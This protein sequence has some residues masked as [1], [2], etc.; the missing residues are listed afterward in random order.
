MLDSDMLAVVLSVLVQS[1]LAVP[2]ELTV[3]Q[4]VR[5]LPVAAA[6]GGK[7]ARIDGVVTFAP[8][9]EGWFYVQDV[10]GGVRVEWPG[11]MRLGQHVIVLGTTTAGTFLPELRAA[12]VLAVGEPGAVRLPRPVEPLLTQD[13]SGY[14]DGRWVEVEVVI[15]RSWVHENWL[16]LDVARGRGQAVVYVPR[17]DAVAVQDAAKLSGAV[18]TVCGV[19][20]ASVNAGRQPSGPPQILVASFDALRNKLKDRVPAAPAVVQ[21][22]DLTHFQPDPIKARQLVV[23]VGVVTLNQ[24]GRQVH[25]GD[26]TGVVQVNLITDS[27]KV[28]PGDC[29]QVKGFPRAADPVRLEN[30]TLEVTGTGPVPAAQPGTPALAA[31]GRL[32]GQIV[33]FRGAVH[34]AGRQGAW[35]TLTV[36]AD[37]Q[38]FTA[39]LLEA[40]G[41]ADPPPAPPGS[42]VEVVGAVTRQPM[43]GIRKTAFVVAVRPGGLTVVEV[44]PGPPPP[45]WWTGRRVAYLSAAFLGLFLCGA[46]AVTALRAQVR[47]TQALVRA[48]DAEKERL[49]GRLEQAARLEAVGRAAGGVA[50]DFNNLLTVINGCA[51]LLGEELGGD[52][53]RAAAAVAD[54]RRAG[55]LATTLNALLLAFGRQREVAPHPLDVAAVVADAA[56]V[57]ARLLPRGCAFR[58]TDTP[59]LPPAMGETGMLLQVLINLTVNAGEAMP[60]GG[61]FTLSTSAPEPGWVRVTAADTGAGMTAEVQA[62]AFDRGFTTKVAGTGTGLSTVADVA[63]TLGWRVLVRS[64]VGRGTVFEIDLPAVPADAPV[65]DAPAARAD[66]TA[67]AA[68]LPAGGSPVVLVVEDDDAVRAFACAALQRAGFAPLAAADAASALNLLAARADPIDVLLTDVTLPDASGH[69]LAA[70]VCAARPGVRVLLMSGDAPGDA[71]DVLAKP[72]TA[73]RLAERVAALAAGR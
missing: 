30:A 10:T 20:R 11:D 58:L 23:F 42:T 46:G 68:P 54:I 17:P 63:R 19:L 55:Q 2:A 43:G 8:R 14:L 51:Q 16:K 24:A 67:G 22:T 53:A 1:G 15:Q 39:V 26:D 27:V 34:E 56:P 36:V 41:D 7:L 5:A 70:R 31:D 47:R 33:R 12:A 35:M 4:A 28:K 72:F 13:D 9:R 52:P 44:P 69:E 45:P 73:A 61:T 18:A 3:A 21:A 40:S 49:E 60:G 48:G 59:G 29:V 57:L 32:E 6:R 66:D 64:E 37:G 38:S 71:P 25:V 50:H 62:R 65:A